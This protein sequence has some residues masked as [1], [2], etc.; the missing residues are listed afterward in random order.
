MRITFR[1]QMIK[2]IQFLVVLYLFLN[3]SSHFMTF[4]FFLLSVA[5]YILQI[6]LLKANWC[7][8]FL[9]YDI[10]VLN[11]LGNVADTNDN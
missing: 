4:V 5:L 7:S 10:Y 6:L 3:T 9:S 11:V 8:Q 2:F 1:L